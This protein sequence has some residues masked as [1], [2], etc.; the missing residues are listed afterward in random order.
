METKLTMSLSLFKKI[1]QVTLRQTIE[2][3]EM[4]PTL[5]SFLGHQSAGLYKIFVKPCF[6]IFY[7][8]FY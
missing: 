5:K 1:S 7:L 6:S 3:G 8:I 2:K 4:V